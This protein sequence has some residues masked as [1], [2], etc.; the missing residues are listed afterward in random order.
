MCGTEDCQSFRSPRTSCRS[1]VAAT[2]AMTVGEFQGSVRAT[3]QNGRAGPP[4]MWK[5]TDWAPDLVPRSLIEAE[6]VR[7][8]LVHHTLFRTPTTSLKK[9]RACCARSTASTPGPRRPGPVSPTTSS[10]PSPARSGEG[11]SG[12]IDGPLVGSATGGSQ[13]FSQLCCFLG[14]FE[15]EPPP[16]SAMIALLAWLADRY[17][18]DVSPG[19]TTSLRLGDRI[20]TLLAGAHLANAVRA[21]TS[22][23]GRGRRR[24]G[25]PTL[26]SPQPVALDSLI[27]RSGSGRPP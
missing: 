21:T 12:S 27:E 14:D 9:L 24:P 5:R 11:R 20:S 26:R 7:F 3:G 17:A 23:S 6:E 10:S 18:A 2:S 8:L 1:F 4:K 16:E 22:T 13:G 25:G 19:A 15:A